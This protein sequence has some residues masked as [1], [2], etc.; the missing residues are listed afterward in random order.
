MYEFLDNFGY[1]ILICDKT[2]I[3]DKS[4]TWWSHHEPSWMTMEVVHFLIKQFEAYKVF[5][6]QMSRIVLSASVVLFLKKNFLKYE[7]RKKI[8]KIV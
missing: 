7:Q 3:L 6:I 5:E 8:F 4:T 2:S 1:L